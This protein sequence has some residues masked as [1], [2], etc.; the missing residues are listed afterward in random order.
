MPAPEVA[1]AYVSIVP[2]LGG[3][4]RTLREQ[5][6]GPSGDAGD[7]AGASASSRLGSALKK[8]AAGAAIAAGALI[9]KG[10]GDAIEQANITNKLKAQLGASG[11]DAARYGKVAGKLYSSG[12]S[13]SFENAAEAIKS[14]MQAGIAPPGAT[15]AQLQ[16]I[17]TKASDVA[18]T[19][20]QDLG[21]VTNAVSQ[22]MRTGLAKNSTEAFDIITKGF[23]SGANKADDL[24]D[25]MNEY[26]TQ[27]RKAGLSGAD[28]IGLMN[29]AIKGGARDS[30]L[31]ADAIKEFSIRAVDGSDTTKAGFK[32][33]GLSA[34]VMAEEFGKGGTS[35]KKALTDTLNGLRGIKDPAKQAQL[36]VDLFGTQ[37]ED[38]GKALY[39]MHP[40]TAAKG[41]GKVGGAA[42]KVGKS[43]RSGPS[44]QLTVFKRRIQQG[45]TEA[46]GTYAIP[47]LVKF[48]KIV[49]DNFVPVLKDVAR[50]AGPTFDAFK[51]AS[52]YIATVAVA[53]GGLALALNAGAIASGISTAATWIGVAAL[54][55][56]AFSTGLLVGAME[57]LDTVMALNPFVLVAIALAA[58]VAGFIVAYKQSDTFRAI[59]QAAWHGIQVAASYAWNS[60]LKPT[61]AA[62]G[63]VVMWLYNTI[64]KPIFGLIVIA[65]KVW[66][67]ATRTILAVVTTIIKGL[68]KV[69]LWLYNNA[70]KP[71][72]TWIADKAKWLYG[73]AIAPQVKNIKVVLNA[74]GNVA[75]GLYNS[76]IKP[77]FNWIASKAAWLYN[78]GVKGPFN[79]MK[80]AV[81]AVGSAF[82]KAGKAI[83]DNWSKLKAKLKSPISFLINT[84]YNKGIVGVYN[85]AAKAFGA[86]TLP[87]FHPKGFSAGG[88]TGPGGK[89]TPAGIVHAGE[90]VTNKAATSSIERS[91][92]GAL[93]Y[94]NQTGK[95]PGYSS[96]GLVGDLFGWVKKGGT[97]LK[98]AGSAVW[99]SIKK[100]A[101]WLKD[102][103]ESSARAGV[104]A[105]VNPLINLMPG[106]SAGFGKM[107]KRI[108]AK[109]ISSMFGFAK[110]ADSKLGQAGG[111]IGNP[112]GSG[113][114]RWKATVIKALAANGLS[115]DS[116]MV[117][118]ILRQIAT[119]SG[120]N[121]KAVQGNIGDI[122][123]KT[124]DLAKGLMQT[125]SATFNANKFPGHGNIFNGYDNLLAA[126]HYAKNR[127]GKSL[128]FLGNGHGYDE[129]GWLQPGVT[130]TVNKTGKPEAILNPAQWQSMSALA[131]RGAQGGLADGARIT[132][133]TQG[134]TFE[135]YVDQR[136]GKQI[137]STLVAPAAL[138]RGL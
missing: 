107:A 55:A 3:F 47:A 41:L 66:W 80:S 2:S 4:Q 90:F 45:I 37:S 116:S 132:L 7:A 120:G 64:I 9:A 35:A 59:V 34:K 11:K 105:V 118:R 75:K 73:V 63:T 83:G 99:D 39:D 1:I 31:A 70:F 43:L 126:L 124:G 40:E 96:G 136:A 50:Y 87:E 114:Q 91:H 8:G 121:P 52:P 38:L 16:T 25:T 57:L 62:I 129:G 100:G 92:P 58:L 44:Y 22:M 5:L 133:V 20:D 67:F 131:Q 24:L 60:V 76:Y 117:A 77:A 123:N 19:F 85:K 86:P 32:G 110:K 88:Y 79:S 106:G 36:A 14:V 12:V 115:T 69:A 48:G 46:L 137:H 113:V 23:Q 125:I 89:Y 15:N 21:G 27:F 68:G 28:A 51:T 109:V 108:P 72:F 101:S 81:G 103:M 97:A 122:N 61:F 74:L 13:D 49:N 135:A 111:T 128:S 26:G 30:D 17:A 53:V 18:N 93:A 119:E 134:G 82:S 127:Y 138:G 65:F 98:G 33:I 104:K 130:K 42:D 6:I 56:A 29:Q 84:V 102:S 78:N 10:L 112:G 71:A 94:M 54:D 95:L